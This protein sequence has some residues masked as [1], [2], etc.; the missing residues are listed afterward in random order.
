[1]AFIQCSFRSRVLGIAAGMNVRFIAWL[2]L[3]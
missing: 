2:A 3:P 1:V